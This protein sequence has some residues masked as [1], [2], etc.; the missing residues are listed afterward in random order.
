MDDYFVRFGSIARLYGSDALVRFRKAHVCVVGLGGV[1]SWIVEALAR[2][3]IGQLTLIDMDEV[4]LSNVNRQVQALSTTVGQ[5]KGAVLKERVGTIAP[6]C[7]V[8]IKTV[9]FTEQTAETLLSEGFDYIADA[10]DSVNHKCHLIAQSKERGIPLITCGGGGGKTDPSRIQ[11]DDLSRT[12]NDPLLNQ[13]RKKLRREYGFPKFNKAK[14]QVPCVFS[15]ETPKFPH[16]DGS[17]QCEREKGADYRLNCDFGF[18]SSTM[19][20]GSLGF[21]MAANVLAQLAGSINEI[22]GKIR[23]EKTDA[24]NNN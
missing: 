12:V 2:S 13:V 10:I 18:G 9:Y 5:S 20:T 17:V 16:A 22:N 19:L 8:S 6:E 3:G 7:S 11:V 1:G 21:T 23:E 24:K 15:D 4:C 14:F